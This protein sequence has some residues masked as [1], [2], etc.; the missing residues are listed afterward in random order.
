[1]LL[2]FTEV[3]FR[4]M[5][6]LCSP[7]V[8]MTHWSSESFQRMGHCVWETEGALPQRCGSLL[9]IYLLLQGVQLLDAAWHGATTRTK[10]AANIGVLFRGSLHQP[11]L[12]HQH[13][14]AWQWFNVA[15]AMLL[16]FTEVSFRRMAQLCSPWVQMTHWSSESFQ[17]MGHCVWETEGALPQRCESLLAIPAAAR[18]A[19]AWC[20]VAWS[21]DLNKERCETSG[22][23]LGDPYTKT[24]TPAWQWFNVGG[25]ILCLIRDD[26]V[27]RRK[28][29]S[30]KTTVSNKERQITMSKSHDDKLRQL[31]SEALRLKHGSA[32]SLPF[33]L[34]VVADEVHRFHADSAFTVWEE[35]Q[36]WCCPQKQHQ[37]DSSWGQTTPPI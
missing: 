17:R 13:I 20:S 15:G 37:T 8:Q 36:S 32:S 35:D 28:K 25:A 26:H 2:W 14:P 24:L 30:P 19:I 34:V 3:S 16:W 1:M 18:S 4:R 29:A 21:D 10:S 7:W 11:K 9:A 23:Y 22:S 31:G 27:L 33:A 5:A 12:W 6:Q